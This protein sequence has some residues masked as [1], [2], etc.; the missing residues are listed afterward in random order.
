M[1]MNI[2]DA[3]TSIPITG[4]AA[5]DI[6]SAATLFDKKCFISKWR[7]DYR[8]IRQ[9]RKNPNF[10]VTISRSAAQALI[11][12]LGLVETQSSA[13]NQASTFRMSI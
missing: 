11:D 3:F 6:E 8:L 4:T 13:F 2:K 12:R 10:K 1:I 9:P 5:M 7:D